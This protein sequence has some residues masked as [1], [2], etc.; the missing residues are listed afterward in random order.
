MFDKEVVKRE[1]RDKVIVK[2]T[3]SVDLD[4]V[5]ENYEVVD[6]FYVFRIGENGHIFQ[7]NNFVESCPGLYAS[8]RG[9]NSG[10]H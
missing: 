9:E 4:E 3:G 8:E 2:E 5:V 6:G 10:G 7:N 1:L